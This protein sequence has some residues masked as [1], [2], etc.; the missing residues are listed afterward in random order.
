MSLLGLAFL[1]LLAGLEV[2]FDMLRGRLLRVTAA[3][4]AL[5]LAVALAAALLLDAGG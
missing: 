4:F 3:G 1:L 5:S 2:R